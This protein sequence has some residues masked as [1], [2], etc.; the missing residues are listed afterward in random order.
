MQSHSC[1]QIMD[2][3]GSK[4]SETNNIQP[5]HNI[6]QVVSYPISSNSEQN[7][8][9]F[10]ENYSL[11]INS[12]NYNQTQPTP[13]V[14]NHPYK[15]IRDTLVGNSYQTNNLYSQH[16]LDQAINNPTSS[17]SQQNGENHSQFFNYQKFN[18]VQPFQQCTALKLTQDFYQEKTDYKFSV[19]LPRIK[20]PN[21]DGDPMAYHDWINMFQAT[22]D[23]NHAIS[24]THRMTYLQDSVSGKA[25]ALIIGTHVTLLFTKP[26]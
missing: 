8:D 4:R 5:Q 3:R 15:K 9:A 14:Q 16:H 23:R 18:Q 2:T 1:N 17:N 11:Y 6:D 13:T 21:Y 26:H 19:K 22:V 24:D 7:R 20:L 12:A 25:K 10:R